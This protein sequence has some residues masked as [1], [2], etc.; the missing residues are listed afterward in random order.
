MRNIRLLC[1]IALA[2]AAAWGAHGHAA[3]LGPAVVQSRLGQPLLVVVPLRDVAG[4]EVAADCVSAKIQ[5][6]TNAARLTPR[7][8]IAHNAEKVVIRLATVE[9]ISDPAINISLTVACGLGVQR[10]YRVLV[11]PE[12]APPVVER[13]QAEPVA[14]SSPAV[15]ATAAPRKQQPAATPVNVAAAKEDAA[16]PITKAGAALP[17]PPKTET[18]NVLK[19]SA[20]VNPGGEP[21]P[22]LGLKL[23]LE[24]TVPATETDPQRLAMLKEEQRRFAALLRDEDLI[25]TGDIALKAA[26]VQATAAQAEIAR[27]KAQNQADLATAAAERNNLYSGGWVTALLALLAAC[28]LGIAVLFRRISA[29]RKEHRIDAWSRSLGDEQ[30][31]IIERAYGGPDEPTLEGSTTALLLEE[32]DSEFMRADEELEMADAPVAEAPS[33]AP[34]RYSAA[35]VMPGLA[36]GAGEARQ[37]KVNQISDAMQL[38]EAWMSFHHPYKV[39]EILEPF[40]DVEQPES[41]IPWICLLDVH[42]VMGDREKYEAILTRIKKIYNVKMPSWDASVGEEPLKTLA[43]FPHIV[44]QIFDLWDSEQI[45][46]YLNGLLHDQRDGEREGFDLPVYRNILQLISLAAEPDPQLRHKHMSQGKAYDILFVPSKAGEDGVPAKHGD[47]HRPAMTEPAPVPLMEALAPQPAPAQPAPAQPPAPQT[48]TSLP[49]VAVPSV[50]RPMP[51]APAAAAP[52]QPARAVRIPP[53]AGRVPTNDGEMSDIAIKL[54]LA[55]AYQDIGDQ[56]GARILIEEVIEH[57]NP[58]QVLKARLLL[59]KLS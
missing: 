14:A 12:V 52:T 45:V 41:P 47:T 54:H 26:M 39:L 48:V 5:S 2:F 18:Q 55:V 58:E 1:R 19:L 37:L 22:E 50:G 53:A 57:G 44:D 8:S 30:D 43:D 10:D 9:N 56:E 36:A 21:R 33:P 42:R 28:A 34:F 27:L 25:A 3:G 35:N 11:D 20:D 31:S 49:G 23:S 4:K 24:L 32:T 17:L 16:A 51:A 6:A 59:T 46:P 7:A 38:A 29:I 15:A 40:K 13:A